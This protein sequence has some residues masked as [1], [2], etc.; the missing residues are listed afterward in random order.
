M[1][2]ETQK[3]LEV[4]L[5]NPLQNLFT[6]Y[7]LDKE[8][9]ENVIKSLDEKSLNYFFSAAKVGNYRSSVNVKDVFKLEPAI[10]AID[11]KYWQLAMHLTNVLDFMPTEKRNDWHNQIHEHKTPEFTLETVK[12]TLTDML[13]SRERY[14]AERVDGLFRALSGYHV[15]NRPQG[16][17]KRM[18]IA[19][20]YA[21]GSVSYERAG[22]IHDLRLVIARIMERP[23]SNTFVSTRTDL[24]LIPRNG[25]WHDFDGGAFRLRC[26]K[27]GTMHFEVHP[28]IAWQ[29]N[30]ILAFLHPMAIPAEFRTKPKR[31]PKAH[32]LSHDLVSFEVL[33]DLD[34]LKYQ[35]GTNVI[36][37]LDNIL[38]K[39][40]E[41]LTYIGGVKKGKE[42]HF[43]YDVSQVLAELRRT[44]AIP[45][46][47]SH[48]YYPTPD[49]VAID[50]VEIAGIQIGDTILEP[51]AGQGGIVKHVPIGNKTTCIEISNLH[52][53]I[54]RTKFPWTTVINKDFLKQTDCKF[55]KI[56]LNP[57]FS[58]GRAKEHIQHAATMLE[59]KGFIVAILPASNKGKIIVDGMTHEY[60]K[61]YHNEFQG[62]SVDVVILKL[63]YEN[64]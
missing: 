62:C 50:A 27:I 3:S 6:D 61:V 53:D 1:K 10:K 4:D 34:R 26:Y 40:E 18:I 32:R 7:N 31:K 52:C 2:L 49:N 8:S 59:H 11:A 42:F 33:A 39:T 63:I 24:D 48:Q 14:N 28:N 19:Y 25:E 21:Y 30:K 60:S 55:N 38:P 58:C 13:M 9:V 56:I 45:E 15:T 36:W 12:A 17:S 29:L 43:D 22:Y 35:N 41:I 47:K 23:S 5:F 54:L 64:T 44:G 57:P 16:F 46:R 20:M 37:W 51:S